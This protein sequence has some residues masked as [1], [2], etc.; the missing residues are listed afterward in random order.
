MTAFQSAQQFIKALKAQTDPP[1]GHGPLKIDLAEQAWNDTS[2]HLPNKAE[3][4]AD[5]ILSKFFKE[6]G[7]GLSTNAL[8]NERYWK[9]LSTLLTSTGPNAQSSSSLQTNL[10]LKSILSRVSIAPV[11][12]AFLN[13]GSQLEPSQSSQLTIHASHCISILYP[14]GVQKLTTE[15]FLESWGSFL[16]YAGNFIDDVPSIKIGL[17]ITKAYKN[18]LSNSS[19]RKKVNNLFVQNEAYFQAWLQRLQDT[20]TAAQYEYLRQ[21]IL[22]CG[23]DTIFNLDTIRQMT[24]SPEESPLFFALSKAFQHDRDVALKAIPALLDHYIAS[25]KRHRGAIIN[26]SSSSRVSNPTELSSASI[27]FFFMPPQSD[28][29][30]RQNVYDAQS[31]LD[32]LKHDVD[33]ALDSLSESCE[34]QT[35]NPTPAIARCLSAVIRVD[36]DL[37]LPS[38]GDLLSRLLAGSPPHPDHFTLLELLLEYHIK[39]RTVDHYIETL[40]SCLSLKSPASPL[41]AQDRYAI[42]HSSPILH[43]KHLGQLSKAT[44][45]FLT[46]GQCSATVNHVCEA[47][48]SLH[49]QYKSAER[50]S[51]S[52][53]GNGSRKSRKSDSTAGNQ[54]DPSNPALTFALT[55]KL[56]QTVFSSIPVTSLPQGQAEQLKSSLAE[57]Q[58]GFVQH[59]L[60]KIVKS[61][62]KTDNATD[63]DERTSSKRKRGADKPTWESQIVLIALLRLQYTLR[64]ARSLALPT[65]SSPKISRRL[66]ELLSHSEDELF[67]ELYLET[68]RTLF[69]QTVAMEASEVSQ[70]IDFA[71]GFVD[72]TLMHRLDTTWSGFAHEL[73]NGQEGRARSGLAVLHIILERW[74]PVIEVTASEQQ[75]KMLAKVVMRIP[76]GTDSVLDGKQHLTAGHLLLRTL[77]SA[78]FWE[79][80]NLRVALLSHLLDSTSAFELEPVTKK[81]SHKKASNF[82]QLVATYRLLLFFPVEYLSS[83]EEQSTSDLAKFILHLLDDSA[84]VTQTDLSQTTLDLFELYCTELLKKTIRADSGEASKVLAIYQQYPI[85]DT[86]SSI[87]ARS[88]VCLVN[89]LNKD[90]HFANLSPDLQKLLRGL[91]SHLVT[92]LHDK[93][94]VA[95]DASRSEQLSVVPDLLTYWHSL[96]V[97]GRWLGSEDLQQYFGPQLVR[98]FGT[99]F[100]EGLQGMSSDWTGRTVTMV[101]AI[102]LQELH[103]RDVM[104]QND[105]LGLVVAT[106]VSQ[107]KHLSLAGK[108]SLDHVVSKACRQFSPAG[109][110]YVLSLLDGALSSDFN[111]SI[112]S[113][114]LVHLGSILLRDHPPNTLKIMQAFFTRCMDIFTDHE[115][116]TAG[117][118][119]VRLQTLEFVAQ[120]CSERPAALRSLDIGSIWLLLSKCLSPSPRHEKATSSATFHQI[121]AVASAIIRLRRDLTIPMLPH[122][123]VILRQ[124]ILSTRQCRPQL[125]SKQTDMVMSTQPRWISA[126]Q[127]LGAEEAKALSRLLETLTTKTIIRVHTTSAETQKAESLAAPFSKHAAYVVK[128]YIEAMNDPLCVLTLDVRKELH[129]GLYALCSMIGEH[130]RDALMI[131]GLDTGGKATMKALWK[132][133]EKQRYS[134]QG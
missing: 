15:A 118:T 126:N 55:A 125:G 60:S 106:Y 58:A 90:I 133:Y 105:Q 73:T 101:I 72:K 66:L 100:V 84:T 89:L 94:R 30:G 123:G 96:L 86:P 102:L 9:L 120:H 117:S 2:F 87:K 17:V 5:W 37:V 70:S 21:A 34:D 42:S 8:T 56:G 124:L 113:S 95:T 51:E 61:L 116:Y 10:W 36:Y 109:F 83:I 88:L 43:P 114:E 20:S 16:K 53:Q 82:A 41:S 33:V 32:S 121:I 6:R 28:I 11:V 23:M 76:L 80:H 91:H 99:G 12:N 79:F 119:E 54:K 13:L 27:K 40:I 4:I 112:D 103:Y 7:D 52:N 35:P 75:L 29:I 92:N 85:F 14:L 45:Q 93:L 71:L 81:S 68:F 130:S 67:P 129:P 44:R 19:S 110:E 111:E 115:E 127:P 48:K 128:A 64:M 18:S 98:R 46:S 132:E 122:L 63:D 104:L 134:G 97:L 108:A 78:Q 24:D 62:L 26:A 47:L 69:D 49:E 57:F 131:S 22:T 77:R 50:R 65:D 1:V 74:L 3:I 107:W 31:G 25:L 39:T 59:N 38:M